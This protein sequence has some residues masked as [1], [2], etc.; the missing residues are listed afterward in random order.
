MAS[1]AFLERCLKFSVKVTQALELIDKD[2][3]GPK[4]RDQVIACSSSIGANIAEAQS[5]Q[6]RADFISKFEIALKEARE[7]GFRL[8][9]L[10]K[11]VA[12]NT[13]LQQWLARECYELTAILAASVKTIKANGI[14]RSGGSGRS[15]IRDQK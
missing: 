4:M 14:G 9:H 1:S 11:V 15:E 3:F 6:S 10:Q 8:A 2:R 7:T 5:A 12:Q 13:E